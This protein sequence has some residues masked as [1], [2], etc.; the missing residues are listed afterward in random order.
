M[1]RKAGF[2]V[3]ALAVIAVGLIVGTLN[4]SSVSLD[5]LWFQLELPLGLAVLS[6]FAFGL[7]AGSAMTW[8]GRVLPLRLQLRK[9][10]KALIKQDAPGLNT[11][12]D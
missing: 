7:L 12:D 11:S 8:L 4:S 1:L 6:G 3:V 10:H 9:T 2:F 5:L